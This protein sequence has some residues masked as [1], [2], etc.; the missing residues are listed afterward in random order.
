MFVAIKKLFQKNGAM[1]S[2]DYDIV[3][4]SIEVIEELTLSID[5]LT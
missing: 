1:I 2:N 5:E 3:S 4:M